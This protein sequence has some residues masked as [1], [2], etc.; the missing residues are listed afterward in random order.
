MYG[1]WIEYFFAKYLLQNELKVISS[2]NEIGGFLFVLFNLVNQVKKVFFYCRG[3]YA[4]STFIAV[5]L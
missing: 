1:A 5:R 2:F 4:L 3:R